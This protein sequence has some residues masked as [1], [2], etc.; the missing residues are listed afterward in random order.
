MNGR[1]KC[2]LQNHIIGENL[3]DVGD[4]K[5]FQMKHQGTI[6]ERKK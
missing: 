1:P 6:H 2:E 4:G 5:T 3:D